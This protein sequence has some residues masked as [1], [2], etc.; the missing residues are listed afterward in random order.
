MVTKKIDFVCDDGMTDVTNGIETNDFEED[1]QQGVR[2][3]G[4]Q[5]TGW[6]PHQITLFKTG[7]LTQNQQL[8]FEWIWYV[9]KK[10]QKQGMGRKL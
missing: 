1:A 10:H 2:R 9:L 6:V 8:G 3:F 7:D 4:E 5:K